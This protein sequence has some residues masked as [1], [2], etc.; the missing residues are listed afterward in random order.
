MHEDA[1]LHELPE[2][3]QE[4]IRRLRVENRSLRTRL[5]KY[6]PATANPTK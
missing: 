4:K 2:Y 3:W 6:E 5:R 1:Q